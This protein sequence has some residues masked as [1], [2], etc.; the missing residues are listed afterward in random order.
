MTMMDTLRSAAARI[1]GAFTRSEE[2]VDRVRETHETVTTFEGD[3]GTDPARESLT[4][5]LVK[6]D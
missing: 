6:E 1:R 5:P 4:D 2:T 3:V